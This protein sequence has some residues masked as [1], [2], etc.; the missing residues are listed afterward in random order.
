MGILLGLCSA[1]LMSAKDIVSKSVSVGADGR[2]STLAS[3]AF[4]LPFYLLL[5]GAL[6]LCGMESFSITGPFLA[7]VLMRATTD[8]FA[9]WLKMEA[10]SHGDLSLVSCVFALS[11][12]LLLMLSPALTGDHLSWRGV[13]CVFLVA[14]GT[15]ILLYRGDT[16]RPA[17]EWRAILLSIGG[18]FAF[19][20]NGILDRL[21]VQQASPTLSGF[22][23][24][25]CS[26]LIIAP[27][28][29]PSATR[30][31]ALLTHARPFTLRGALEVPFMVAKLWALQYLAAPYVAALQRASMLMNVIAGRLLFREDRFFQRIFA[32]SLMLLGIV[33]IAI[34]ATAHPS[35]K[36][37][38][39]PATP[40]SSLEYSAPV[41]PE[42]SG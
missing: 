21:A 8:S 11:P 10:F 30:R 12:V 28:V 18:S 16:K 17:R 26:A 34:E 27:T 37:I 20:L 35:L 29:L 38:E 36:G 7:Y 40:T 41:A 32:A 33:G 2:T 22:A 13:G 23:M 24:T 42:H 9:E 15:V 25:L 5:L 14:G 6:W 19:A 31:A 4:A 39:T 3:F 1:L